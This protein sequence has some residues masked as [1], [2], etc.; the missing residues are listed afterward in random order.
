LLAKSA[1]LQLVGTGAA[2][3]GAFTGN[4][5]AGAVSRGVAR[6]SDLLQEIR[7]DQL[8]VLLSRDASNDLVLEDFTLVAPEVRLTGK[9]RVTSVP[10]R[11]L[12]ALP[13]A[14]T[15]QLA[16]R[17]SVGDGLRG[18]GLIAAQ[19]DALGYYPMAF[20]PQIGGTVGSPDKTPFYNQLM[21]RALAALVGGALAPAAPASGGA[22]QSVEGLLKEAAGGLLNGL[23]K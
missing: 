5:T 7:F 9:G 1:P 12:A 21:Q 16:A 15:F 8:N 3:L 6:I 20:E 2:L 17:G 23:L 11:E 14:L 22:E 13:L 10:G 18:L 4:S 19:P